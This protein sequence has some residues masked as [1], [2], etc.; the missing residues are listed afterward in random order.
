MTLNSARPTSND[1]HSKYRRQ[2]CNLFDHRMVEIEEQN[3]FFLTQQSQINV[4]LT[5]I[6]F[7]CLGNY[8]VS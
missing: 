2:L 6:S 5:I 3:H 8:T 4:K 1:F 7:T